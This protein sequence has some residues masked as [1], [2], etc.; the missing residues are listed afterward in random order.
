MGG[1]FVSQV[2]ADAVLILPGDREVKLDRPLTIGRD[3]ASALVFKDAR[4]SRDHALVHRC[5]G[6][7][8]VEDRGSFNGTYVNGVRV[9]ARSPQPLRHC[10]RIV[11]G[12]VPLLFAQVGQVVDPHATEELKPLGETDPALLSPFQLQVVRCLCATWINTGSL[13]SVPSNREIAER[14]G[15]PEAEGAV[16]A[17]L[18]RVYRKAGLTDLPAQEKRRQLC[19]VARQ[20]GWL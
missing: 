3:P 17:A 16:K 6:R 13:A 2:V 20:R 14:L 12:A 15:T 1:S 19:R 5:D 9:P 11:V 8:C 18:R 7:W 10:D 4:V